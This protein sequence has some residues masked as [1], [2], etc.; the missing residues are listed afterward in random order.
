MT[1]QGTLFDAVDL[2][3]EWGWLGQ[4]PRARVERFTDSARLETRWRELVQRPA[5]NTDNVEA[6]ARSEETSAPAGPTREVWV[7]LAAAGG[8]R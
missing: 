6:A 1:V 7:A 4:V 5:D 8:L 3:I 2:F